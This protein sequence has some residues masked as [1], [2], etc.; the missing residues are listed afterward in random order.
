MIEQKQQAQ[1]ALAFLRQITPRI[2]A[3]LHEHQGILQALDVLERFV[4]GEQ[5]S[6][7]VEPTVVK[8]NENGNVSD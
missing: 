1:Q 4:G 3:Q 6:P 7:P 8:E 5:E 2:Q